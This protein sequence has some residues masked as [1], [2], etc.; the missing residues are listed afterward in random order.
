L[1]D[2]S[3]PIN[4]LSKK[5]VHLWT[6]SGDKFVVLYLKE[7]HMAILKRIAGDT[8]HIQ[9]EGTRVAIC[10]KTKLPAIIPIDLRQAM[11]EDPKVMKAVLS[12]TSL[13]RVIDCTGVVDTGA[14]TM[15][16]NGLSP[17]LPFVELEEA[18]S[19]LPRF[20]M[21]K[22]PQMEIMFSSGPNH[23]HAV[24]GYLWDAYAWMHMPLKVQECF[25]YLGDYHKSGWFVRTWIGYMLLSQ[26]IVFIL[27]IFGWN[28]SPTL[29]RLSVKREPAGKRRIFAITD[30]WTQSILRPLHDG[31]F[32]LLRKLPMDGTFNQDRPLRNLVDR[33]RGAPL[34]SYD[35]KS[36]TDRLPVQ[37][38]TD[39]LS[40]LTNPTY[41]T[42]WATVLT[43]RDWYLKGKPY[44][45][46]VG[47]PMGALS[48]WG[49][50]ALTH[51]VIVRV[52]ALR[53]G[54]HN[55]SGYCVLGDDIV[56]ADKAVAA[57]YSSIL[58]SLGV[59]IS[60]HKSLISD[61][62]TCE[63]AKR[64]VGHSEFTPVGASLLVLASRHWSYLPN[65]FIDLTNKGVFLT[66]DLIVR[67]FS[68]NPFP[69]YKEDKIV[70]VLTSLV[71]PGGFF[72]HS[73]S[74][75]TCMED[76][77][78]KNI[79]PPI[80]ITTWVDAVRMTESRKLQQFLV[81][82][83]VMIKDYSFVNYDIL[84]P[85]G[86][87]DWKAPYILRLVREV[88]T[89]LIWI[90]VTLIEVICVNILR[91]SVKD[92]N[93][94]FR[95]SVNNYLSLISPGSYLLFF[96]LRRVYHEVGVE[97]NVDPS[98]VF[99]DYL[100]TSDYLSFMIQNGFDPSFSLSL[101][102]KLGKKTISYFEGE[103]LTYASLLSSVIDKSIPTSFAIT[104]VSE[105]PTSPNAIAIR[106]PIG[107]QRPSLLNR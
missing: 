77:A 61:N 51:H 20:Y 54:L 49:M 8:Y 103:V 50:L 9:T 101:D 88:I 67:Q 53:V 27:N 93:K 57:S 102:R 76:W 91:I 2:L 21:N 40:I 45:Y 36:A 60:L 73:W 84:G 80:P 62:G 90:P 3:V 59:E 31:I 47:Q 34:Y 74:S 18:L 26:P 5:I 19:E 56:I 11:L 99:P 52:A 1:K 55:F 68:N 33:F 46:S 85:S 69:F 22:K 25:A 92:F 13:Y 28:R 98:G 66:A 97:G 107:Y 15:P 38:Q 95:D 89:Y 41:A 81:D 86:S 63:F 4:S 87:R 79:K 70:R 64:V 42:S 48:S 39:I 71:G 10:P 75:I 30:A 104:T 35:L 44:R 14:I 23:K 65:L 7:A 37:L 106:E 29:G 16:F 12:M 105:L 32:R 58:K 24:F 72:V 78:R 17:S 82:C 94:I 100:Y 6:H 96:R 43:A 83:A